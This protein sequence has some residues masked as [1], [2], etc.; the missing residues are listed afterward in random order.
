MSVADDMVSPL[1]GDVTSDRSIQLG[2]V[3]GATTLSL[4]YDCASQTQVSGIGEID[5]RPFWIQI[6]AVAVVT[7]VGYWPRGIL[8]F[9]GI[10]VKNRRRISEETA[11]RM[12][13]LA[14]FVV[15]LQCTFLL[16]YIT[17]YTGGTFYSPYVQ[18]LLAMALLSPVIADSKETVLLMFFA[19]GIVFAIFGD[20][21][22][23]GPP[24]EL[25]IPTWIF[26]AT[27]LAAM[28]IALLNPVFGEVRQTQLEWRWFRREEPDGAQGV[29]VSA[30]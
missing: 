8:R 6:A 16:G 7:V 23:E 5:W 14:L 4:L 17:Q 20:W 30:E 10:F 3:L 25:L 18:S 26:A 22:G 1:E 27:P 24:D 12:K 9:I 2:V 19:V 13:V 15:S 29:G 11:D 21:S 28:A